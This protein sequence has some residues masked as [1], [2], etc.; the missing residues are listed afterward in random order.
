MFACTCGVCMHTCVGFVHVSACVHDCMHACIHGV[1]LHVYVCKRMC[2]SV[3]IR[4]CMHVC[5]HGHISRIVSGK[6]RV[7]PA[8][9]C[10]K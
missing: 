2:I 9:N 8:R 4:A 6:Y 3:H 7:V 10:V 5:V 1:C